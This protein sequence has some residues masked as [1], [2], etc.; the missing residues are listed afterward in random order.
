M[1]PELRST[2]PRVMIRQRNRNTSRSE[3]RFSEEVPGCLR[4]TTWWR[5]PHLQIFAADACRSHKANTR[6]NALDSGTGC[7]RVAV[8]RLMVTEPEREEHLHRAIEAFS[9]SRPKVFDTVVELRNAAHSCH[10]LVG[11]A[12][13]RLLL[14][15]QALYDIF[16]FLSS[17]ADDSY[18]RTLEPSCVRF[19][20]WSQAVHSVP[21]PPISHPRTVCVTAPVRGAFRLIQPPFWETH[22]LEV[23]PGHDSLNYHWRRKVQTPWGSLRQHGLLPP[24]ERPSVVTIDMS[25]KNKISK[26]TSRASRKQSTDTKLRTVLHDRVLVCLRFAVVRPTCHQ[27]DHCERRRRGALQGACW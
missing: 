3:E 26:A 24:E 25:K 4:D 15:N 7:S 19:D 6:A 1:Y 14:D 11:N 20:V 23:R 27:N 21:C 17:D 9:V 16:L 5:P 12:E 2:D 8:R 13:E 22:T 10:Q 18:L